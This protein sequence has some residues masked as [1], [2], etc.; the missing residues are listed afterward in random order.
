MPAFEIRKTGMALKT[1][2]HPAFGSKVLE[3]VDDYNV[4]IGI[5]VGVDVDVGDDSKSEKTFF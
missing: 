1:M 2:N 3:S 4:G 5:G